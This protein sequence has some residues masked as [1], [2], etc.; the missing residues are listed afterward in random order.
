MAAPLSLDA[1]YA[2]LPIASV[3]WSIQRNDELSGDGEGDVWQA[4]LADPFWTGDV[5]LDK[6]EN[7][8]LK[9]CAAAIRDLE[10]AKQPFMLCDPT[11][12]YPQADPS[13]AVLGA[14]SVTIR[15]VNVNRRIAQLGGLPAGY[16]LTLGDKFQITQG[17]ML[18]FHEISATTVADGAGQMDVRIF[19]R[20]PLS[21]A[22]GAVIT[23]V[24]PAC[25][26]IIQSGSHEP[27]TA[28]NTITDGASF[29]ALQ[30]RR[31]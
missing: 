7:D 5:A 11:S 24:R 30:K 19:P 31:T 2:L 15:A 6:G 14:S 20:L 4:E 23:L 22:I 26:V 18:R 16:K 8:E 21:L 25:P 1:V 9:Q 13:G 29:R 12:E 27:G 28:R 10:G 3:K 17:S